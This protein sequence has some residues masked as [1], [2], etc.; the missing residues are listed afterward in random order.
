MRVVGVLRQAVRPRDDEE[1]EEADAREPDLPHRVHHGRPHHPT[2][3][4]RMFRVSQAPFRQVAEVLANAAC[5]N[6]NTSSYRWECLHSIANNIK[7][8]ACKPTCASCV[9]RAQGER[10]WESGEK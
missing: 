1:R 7:G 8:I 6:L 4:R 3:T 9:N 5:K 2:S 10:G